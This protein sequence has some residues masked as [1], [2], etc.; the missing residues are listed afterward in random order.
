L[1]PKSQKC[2]HQTEKKILYSVHAN[3]K[4]TLS[5]I[6]LAFVMNASVVEES[7]ERFFL[8]ALGVTSLDKRASIHSAAV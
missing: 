5:L 2:L 8:E 3:L 1:L 7:R 6:L 4:P